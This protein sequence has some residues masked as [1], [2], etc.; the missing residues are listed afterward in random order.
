MSKRFI[1]R[2]YNNIILSGKTGSVTKHSTEVKLKKESE[3][4]SLLPKDLKIFFPRKITS[5]T[6]DKQYS[7]TLEYFAYPNLGELMVQSDID[8]ETWKNIGENILYVLSC[9]KKFKF[10][11]N[12]HSLARLNMFIDK[13]EKEYSN[14]INNFKEFKEFSQHDTI[15]INGQKYNNFEKMWETAKPIITDYCNAQDFNV[16]HG[17]LCFSNVLCDPLSGM[18][19]LIDPRGS[20]GQDGIY[21]D[22]IYDAAKLLHSIEGKYELIICDKYTINY[23]LKDGTVDFNFDQHKDLSFIKD[24]IFKDFDEN[25][26]K[27]IM[28]TIFIGMCARHYDSLERQIIMYA[29]GIK[30]MTEALKCI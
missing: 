8:D 15:I 25:K 1:T 6:T 14:L 7:L 24:I 9:F 30:S 10:P 20:F 22:S 18:L 13:T 11:L 2:A 3:Y 17:D 29:T 5:E 23:N 4:Y 26:V 16:I 19:R 28:S 21:G 27:L 12:S